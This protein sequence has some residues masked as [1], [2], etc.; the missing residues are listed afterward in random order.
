M[1]QVRNERGTKRKGL[2]GEG[3]N[4]ALWGQ[5]GQDVGQ[6]NVS[7]GGSKASFADDVVQ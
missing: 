3:E 5:L 2:Q 4:E 7:G 6:A 1:L